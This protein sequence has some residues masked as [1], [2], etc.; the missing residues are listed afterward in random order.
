M[1]IDRPNILAFPRTDPA[2]EDPIVIS[3]IGLACSLGADRESV[4]Q[5]IQMGDSGVRRTTSQ[6]PFRSFR[7]P[8]GMVD[9]LDADPDTLK[10]IQ[11]TRHVAEAALRDADVDWA[12]TDRTRFACSIAGQMG[13]MRYLYEP[14][15][16]R[17]HAP[18]S[19]WWNQFLPCSVTQIISSE[20]GLW[21][22]RT[23]H[24]VACASGLVSTLAGVRMLQADEADFVLCGAGD[25]IC[26]L[27]LAAFN[28]LGVLADSPDPK[29]ACRPFDRSRCGFVM[30]EGAALLVLEKRSHAEARGARVYAQLAACQALC[31]AHH[32]TGLD[33]EAET[34]TELIRQ[35]VRKAGWFR[36]G[37]QYINAHGTGTQQNDLSELVA[38]R[39]ALG[40]FADETLVSSNKAVLGHLINAAGSV[41]L[42]I[43]ALAIRD[44]FVPPTMHLTDP[45]T[46]GNLDCLPQ[47]GSQKRIDRALKLSLAFGGHLVGVALERCRLDGL[48]RQPLP[49]NPAARIRET[50][51]ETR[52]RAA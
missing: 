20:F 8:C 36:G 27:F 9:W 30:G 28:R 42:A 1:A 19:L 31:Q 52:R 15:A 51:P 25:A 4:W 3:G 43:T 32:L 46:V 26:E 50:L 38:I 13:D 6:D 5:A 12:K 41:E 2:V 49:L 14:E 48:R 22:P 23:S 18:Q 29:L 34:L 47:Y 40:D 35:L 39:S 37:P 10:S 7:F 21:G 45:E 17:N 16:T 24:V 44:G 11:L 33:G